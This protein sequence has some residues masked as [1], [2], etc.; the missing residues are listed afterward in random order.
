MECQQAR[1]VDGI[2]KT[3]NILARG[4]VPIALTVKLH[5][6]EACFQVKLPLTRVRCALSYPKKVLQDQ[7][8]VR[9]DHIQRVLFFGAGQVK[10]VF[11]GFD[12]F[13]GRDLL[14]VDFKSGLCV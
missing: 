9:L 13:V 3:V 12:V 7:L 10:H 4:R 14:H 5:A 2:K 11:V 6:I 1:L 8:V